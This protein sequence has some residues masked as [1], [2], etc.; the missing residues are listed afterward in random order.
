MHETTEQTGFAF[1]QSEMKDCICR[2]LTATSS[3]PVF[4]NSKHT[5]KRNVNSQT[6]ACDSSTWPGVPGLRSSVLPLCKPY[7][8][9]SAISIFGRCAVVCTPV[10]I[11]RQR[12]GAVVC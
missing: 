2:E 8:S 4:K 3:R 1:L 7:D 11:F 6:P 9:S 10:G 5:D 12:S